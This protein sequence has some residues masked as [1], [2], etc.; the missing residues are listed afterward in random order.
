MSSSAMK[1][2]MGALL[3]AAC[4]VN[5]TT[6]APAAV[7]PPTPSATASAPPSAVA[8]SAA[9]SA[10]PS[11]TAPPSPT[12]G[13][14]TRYGYIVGSQGSNVVPRERETDAS[15]AVGERYAAASHD[16][17]RVAYWRTGPPGDDLQEL[18][19]LELATGTDRAVTTAPTGWSGGAIAWA[20]DD[21]GLL[22]ETDRVRDPNAPP[23]PPS[24]PP[25]RMW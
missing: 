10:A 22:Y 3:L 17:R 4:A 19:V 23:G 12:A 8:T 18:R 14:P 6:C 11:S 25:S 20:T 2:L 15:I 9:P 7:A 16:G 13:D 5:V 1:R 24:A 21:D